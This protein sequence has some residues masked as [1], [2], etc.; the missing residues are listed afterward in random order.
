[1]KLVYYFI[2]FLVVFPSC[3]KE[4]NNPITRD[5]PE[6]GFN[7]IDAGN[8]HRLTITKGQIFS[9]LATGEERDINEL[10][11]Q[12]NGTE[13]KVLYSKYRSNR[14]YVYLNI[15]LPSLRGL[16]LSGQA[17]AAIS[18][19]SESGDAGFNI[20]G[21][22]TCK[23]NMTSPAFDLIASGQSKI[24]FLG[25]SSSVLLSDASGQSEIL[26]Y[27]LNTVD[28]AIAVATGQS[29]IKLKVNNSLT[30]EASGQSRIYYR[31]SPTQKSITQTGQA[32]VIQD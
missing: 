14:K 20:T 19:F 6:T 28:T 10:I 2:L 3:S 5:F 24:E 30:A 27:N 9:I 22:S 32:K 21:Q 7:K 29:K 16:K 4:P 17:E 31:G 12:K 25:G 8:Q 11:L 23:V 18:G 26:T 13:L 1:M 15:I